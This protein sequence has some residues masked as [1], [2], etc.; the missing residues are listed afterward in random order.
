MLNLLP[1]HTETELVNTMQ[2]SEFQEM[3]RRLYLQRDLERGAKGNY[4]WLVDEVKEL[5]EALDN[6]NKEAA[7]EEFADVLAWLASLA[8]TIGIDL[9][10]AAVEKYNRKCPKCGHCPCRCSF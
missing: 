1:E 3:M 6:N 7:Q 5:G 4:D 10:T 9:E 8:N 2:I